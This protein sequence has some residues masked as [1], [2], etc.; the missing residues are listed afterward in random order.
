MVPRSQVFHQRLAELS[1]K[2]TRLIA[3]QWQLPG[4]ILDTLDAQVGGAP[5]DLHGQILYTADKLSKLNIL[6]ARGRF[7]EQTQALDRQ[8]QGRTNDSF[9]VCYQVSAG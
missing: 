1:R 6:A 8:L 7:K 9:R 5:I 3:G 4:M 2:L